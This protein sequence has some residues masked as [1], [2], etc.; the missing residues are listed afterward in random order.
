MASRFQTTFQERVRPAIERAFAVDI[1][2]T[3]GSDSVDGGLTALLD[4]SLFESANSFGIT[5]TKTK[6]FLIQVDQLIIASVVTSP[7]KGDVIVWEANTYVVTA[8]PGGRPD[9]YADDAEVQW[10][11]HATLKAVS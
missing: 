8:P 5:Q 9:E 7:A 6:D 3:R 1:T 2:Y 4:S 11:V 10:G